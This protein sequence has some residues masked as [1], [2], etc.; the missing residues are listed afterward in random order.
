MSRIIALSQIKIRSVQTFEV[1]FEKYTEELRKKNV[2]PIP[3]F[4]RDLNPTIAAGRIQIQNRTIASLQ[5]KNTTKDK[6]ARVTKT[7]EILDG[8]AAL[9]GDEDYLKETR[10]GIKNN[11]QHDR[12]DAYY[13]AE[14][15]KRSIQ[16][17]GF[18]VTDYT[19]D[20]NC[21]ATFLGTKE[22]EGELVSSF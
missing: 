22:V 9:T 20:E 12:L 15:A 7:G 19:V 8:Y 11:I 1:A 21:E 2:S 6:P 4:E 13:G 5:L 16:N 17:L 3:T 10:S 18:D 14:A